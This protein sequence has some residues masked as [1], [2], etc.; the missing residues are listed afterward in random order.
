MI[1]IPINI[2]RRTIFSIFM[3]HDVLTT[4]LINRNA[5]SGINNK[6]QK[7]KKKKAK[8]KEQRHRLC[9]SLI[10]KFSKEIIILK[11]K[12]QGFNQRK[13]LGASGDE[14]VSEFAFKTVFMHNPITLLS[15]RSSSFV[16]DKSLLH[17]NKCTSLGTVDLSVLSSRFPVTSFRCSVCSESRWIFPVTEA[18]EVPFFLSQLSFP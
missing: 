8:R 13:Y 3:T 17:P 6:C 15:F 10:I 9:H 16:K 18:K 1:K 4:T 7:K 5:F 14:M 2:K 12:E 11:I